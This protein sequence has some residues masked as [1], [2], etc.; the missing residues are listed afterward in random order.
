MTGPAAVL[1]RTLRGA[2]RS[3]VGCGYH[4]PVL[5]SRVKCT[6]AL[7]KG[8][9]ALDTGPEA[10]RMGEQGRRAAL[11]HTGAG[12]RTE[13]GEMNMIIKLTDWQKSHILTLLYEERLEAQ[14]LLAEYPKSADLVQ[15]LVNVVDAINSIEIQDD[16]NELWSNAACRAYMIAA[17]SAAGVDND[18]IN[19]MIEALEAA[20]ENWT[21]EEA[22]RAWDSG[23]L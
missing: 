2:L 13:K 17:A 1:G 6:P 23:E 15:N 18:T 19:R 5:V 11:L 10:V 8:A 4:V 22:E 21:I 3:P 7:K 16:V 14:R 9:G 20:F 12:G